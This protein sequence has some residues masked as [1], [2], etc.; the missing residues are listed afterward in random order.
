MTTQS[1]RDM[2]QRLVN[3]ENSFIECVR[4]DTG[5]TQAQ[6]ETVMA[7]FIKHKLMKL[8][9]NDGQFYVKHGAFLERD[10]L[11]RALK[12]AEGKA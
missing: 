1:Y 11:T 4:R 8:N 9:A 5:F 2:A 3:A 6:A 12:Q 10:V 7:Y